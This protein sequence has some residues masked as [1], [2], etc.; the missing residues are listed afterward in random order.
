MREGHEPQSKTSDDPRYGGCDTA[1]P[2]TDD[3]WRIPGEAALVLV[4]EAAG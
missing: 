2:E 1:P 3:G 4:P